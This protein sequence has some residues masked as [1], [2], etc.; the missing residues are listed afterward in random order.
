MVTVT[1]KR[2]FLCIFV[3]FFV[4]FLFFQDEKFKLISYISQLYLVSAKGKFKYI[5]LS[6][7]LLSRMNDSMVLLDQILLEKM[8]ESHNKEREELKVTLPKI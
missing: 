3:L 7:C 1:K 6:E 8:R 5:S 2:I 4:L